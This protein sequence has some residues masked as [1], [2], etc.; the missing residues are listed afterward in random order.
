VAQSGIQVTPDG[1]RTLINKDVGDE[2]WAITRNADDGTVTGNVFFPDGGDPAFVWCSPVGEDDQSVT[3]DCSGAEACAAAPC[4][5]EAWTPLGEVTL[6]RSF[7]AP[8]SGAGEAWV[9]LAPLAAGARQEHAVVALANEV[10]VLG[11]FDGSAR[12]LDTVEAYDPSSDAWRGDVARLPVAMHH[13]NA[14]VVEGRIHV[15]GFLTGDFVADGRVFTYDPTE[16]AWTAGMPMP[17][18]TERG[19]SGVA[20]L[21]GRIHVA[22]GLRDGTV[23]DFSAYDPATGQWEILP[24]LPAPLD[25]LAAAAFGG[26]FYALAGRAGGVLSAAVYEYDPAS[27]SWRRRADMPTARGGVAGALLGGEIFVVGGEG[28]PEPGSGGVFDDNEA[29]DPASDT[30]RTHAPM[31]TPRHGMGAAALGERLYV[32][33]GATVQGF[34]ATA[35]ADAF[36]P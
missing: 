29:Y 9:P 17:P 36:D 5:P 4:A 24:D 1:K 15:V 23:S 21:A 30:W 19:A 20:V 28:N 12:I 6:P 32:P 25:H 2:R 18:G 26:R 14:A 31:R 3:L 34:G 16:D 35:V 22:G 10:F 7:F 8:P 13:V 27:R 11:G 33:G